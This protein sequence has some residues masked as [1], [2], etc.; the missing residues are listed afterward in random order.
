MSAE[1]S[2]KL[3]KPQQ[4]ERD[5]SPSSDFMEEEN[6]EISVE[7]IEATRPLKRVRADAGGS[8]SDA[9]NRSVRLSVPQKIRLPEVPGMY[10]SYACTRQDFAHCGV[11]I[12]C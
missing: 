1:S 11:R 5:K 4:R 3:T 8:S 12:I 10:Y 6:E 2:R 9:S 7:E